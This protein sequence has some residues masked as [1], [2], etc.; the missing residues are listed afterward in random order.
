MSDE[1]ADQG[2]DIRLLELRRRDKGVVVKALAA[3][4]PAKVRVPCQRGSAMRHKI[5]R[6]LP[7]H[8]GSVMRGRGR[9]NPSPRRTRAR[10]VRQGPVE[11]ADWR[12]KTA[13]SGNERPEH[14]RERGRAIPFDAVGQQILLVD[15]AIE[16]Q[17]LNIEDA[18]GRELKSGL[19]SLVLPIDSP[20]LSLNG[21]R[22]KR[23]A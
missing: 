2:L 8:R 12:I 16:E 19:E 20:G 13:C 15:R 21:G 4:V 6:L 23:R 7:A 18:C 14:R 17:Q 22:N 5:E 3:F 1:L 10:S 9:S 11:R